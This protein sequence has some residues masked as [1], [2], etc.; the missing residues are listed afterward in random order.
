MGNRFVLHVGMAVFFLASGCCAAGQVADAVGT[1]GR[2]SKLPSEGAAA[3]GQDE[4]NRPMLQHRNPRYR[5]SP[6]DVLDLLF[7]FTPEFDQTVT[8]QPDGHINLRG[9]GD[10]YV[11]GQT[12]PE[13]T[14]VLQAAYKRIL[15]K[16]VITVQLKDFQKPYF[17]VAGEV[18]HPGKYDLRGETTLTQAVAIAGG[19]TERAKHS[20]VLLV[21]RISDGRAEVKK[22]DLKHMLRGEDLSE[23][24]PLR[25]GDMMLVPKNAVA[26]IR[27]FIPTASIG[28]YF[29]PNRF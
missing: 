15:R 23:D 24:L 20:Q 18:E 27:R 19:F 7:S 10:L 3:T 2:G 16:P 25:S 11:E 17:V 12:E 26:S 1:P 5:L 22:F 29:N 8:V 28:L 21:R 6:G 13:L 14:Q 4:T 9:V